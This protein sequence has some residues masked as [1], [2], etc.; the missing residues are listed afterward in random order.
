LIQTRDTKQFLPAL[1]L[2][3]FLKKRRWSTDCLS[4]TASGTSNSLCQS[5]Q[6][7]FATGSDSGRQFP[8]GRPR[9][10]TKSG[11]VWRFT[12][13]HCTRSPIFRLTGMKRRNIAWLFLS[14]GSLEARPQGSESEF[15]ILGDKETILN[16][17][18][19][20]RGSGQI[21]ATTERSAKMS[22]TMFNCL[23]DVS[24]RQNY[25]QWNQLHFVS[26]NGSNCVQDLRRT[27]ASHSLWQSVDCKGIRGQSRFGTHLQTVTGNWSTRNCRPWSSI[28]F[29][30]V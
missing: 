4:V 3:Q 2:T 15:D 21:S 25:S 12:P 24:N 10:V 23:K 28:L 1:L 6:R 17:T 8:R 27:P 18:K 30:K 5:K 11:P 19:P 29:F 14:T 22:Q 16:P 20:T 9:T 7:P 26:I 13:Q